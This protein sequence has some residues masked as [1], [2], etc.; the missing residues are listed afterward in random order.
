MHALFYSIRDQEKIAVAVSGGSDSLAMLLMLAEWANEQGKYLHCLTVDHALRAASRDE[1]LMVG[2][3]CTKLGIPHDILTWDDEKPS[4][5]LSNAARDAR[6][7]LMAERCLALGVFDLVLGHQ[8]DDQ[9]E[10]LLMRLSR[11]DQGGRGLAG[12]PLKTEYRTD[13]NG[14]ITL[15]RPLL[16][17]ARADLQG[18]LS[19][20]A[21]NWVSDPTNDNDAY[22]RVRTRTVLGNNQILSEQLLAYAKVSARYRS[23]MSLE[24]A[25]FI[26]KH[27]DR[28]RFGGL[29]VDK[30]ALKAQP[31]PVA[32]LVLQ[33]LLSV[34]GGRDYL[35]SVADVQRVLEGIGGQTLARVRLHGEGSSLYLTREVRNL[36]CVQ[37]LGDL[38]HSWDRRFV[39]QTSHFN[40]E[41][42]S[43]SDLDADIV[44]DFVE[45][46]QSPLSKFEKIALQSSPFVTFQQ[47]GKINA[48]SCLEE[49]N[50]NLVSV[51]PLFGGFQRFCGAFDLPIKRAVER[52]L[53]M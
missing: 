42:V 49:D 30:A 26:S 19:A 1:A 52:L 15:H 17:L 51:R 8:R 4:T 18:F 46:A 27:V 23:A 41:L 35:P 6:Y 45:T 13:L 3:L 10:T 36:P 20:R 50:S 24:V 53:T 34:I 9:A 40:A 33:T 5:G 39:I 25:R 2:K 44:K 29:V 37:K 14:P 48:A 32:V 28:I 11:S 22:E 47:H 7:E 38:A 16:G 12:M 31:E 21:V 43:G